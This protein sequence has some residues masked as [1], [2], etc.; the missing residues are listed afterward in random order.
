[1]TGAA[2][3]REGVAPAT[4]GSRSEGAP[5]AW[6][7][8]LIGRPW[9]WA[10]LAGVAAGVV[11]AVAI[12][13]PGPATIDPD[14]SASVLYF[15]RLLAGRHLEAFVPTTPKPLLTLVYGV[16]WS[17]SHDWRTL[18]WLTVAVHA[19]AVACAAYLGWKLVSGLGAPGSATW[20]FVGGTIAAGVLVGGL[21]GWRDELLEVS[22]ANSLVWVL[23]A[24]LAAACALAASPRR[25]GVAGSALLV[26]G[27]LRAES[28]MLIGPALAWTAWLTLRRDRVSRES[29]GPRHAS[30]GR[31]DSLRPYLPRDDRGPRSWIGRPGPWRLWIAAL[32]FPA[33]WLHDLLLTG[34][35]LFSL[36]V[37]SRYTLLYAPAL[38]PE[39]PI[40]F[41]GPV[42]ERY[43]GGPVLV[44]LAIA[45]VALLA[46]RGRCWPAAGLL[47]LA[48]GDLGIL[49]MLAVRGIYVSARYFETID[50]ALLGAASLGAGALAARAGPVVSER[51][52]AS[53]GTWRLRAALAARDAGPNRGLSPSL[54]ALAAAALSG[55]ALG[56]ALL[57]PPGPVD[58]STTARLDRVRVASADTLPAVTELAA[59]IPPGA[60]WDQVAPD[61]RDAPDADPSRAI[62]HVPSTLR[63]RVA[64]ELDLPL[65]YVVD[66]LAAYLPLGP[67][68]V[69]R[70]GQLVWH[71]AAADPSAPAYRPLYQPFELDEV[72]SLGNVRVS[73]VS[74]RPGSWIVR[75]QAP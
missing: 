8:P 42:L 39:D 58:G 55:L 60:G 50:A 47:V 37:A 3:R 9:F 66:S 54:P 64:V 57:W 33:W 22:R 2:V 7:A 18:V 31:A 28:W 16:T 27:V 46:A 14:A 1:V 44:A 34:N 53:P 19:L 73:P 74:M 52:A 10:A 38:R 69:L 48:A 68:A 17:L 24:W 11:A 32:A 59:L 65:T 49:T 5:P 45:G 21:A 67:G 13:A 41:L 25:W 43:A 20:R 70:P 4:N 15:Q 63:S 56:V 6:L 75:I 26:A 23:A 62:L 51:L 12:D 72:S 29:G 30:H 71:D 40:G 35:P 61:A 36:S